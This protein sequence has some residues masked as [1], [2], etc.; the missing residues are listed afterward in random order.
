MLIK[1]NQTMSDTNSKLI[2]LDRDGTLIKLVSYINDVKLVELLP[3]VAS[4]LNYLAKIGFELAIATN[5]S[6]IGRGI[7]TVKQ[8]EE[9]N[10]KVIELLMDQQVLIKRVMYCP[11]SPIDF[12]Q[13]RKPKPSMGLKIMKGLGVDPKNTVVIG[14]QLSDVEFAK[15]IGASYIYFCKD[16]NSPQ[17]FAC[18]DWK[19]IPKLAQS[20]VFNI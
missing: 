7:A 3:G 4:S 6:A 19:D 9:V 15:N 14:D 5:Q 16:T 13:C 12:C 11:H 20:L 17:P 18:S 8:V 1:Y 2:I 10:A